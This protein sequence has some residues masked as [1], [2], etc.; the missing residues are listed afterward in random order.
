MLY[1]A[2]VIGFIGSLHCVGMCG[3][4][5]LMLPLN[6]KNSVIAFLQIMQYHL[7]RILSY[8]FLGLIFGLFGRGLF[9]AG[10]QQ[11]LSLWIG[12]LLIAGL[13]MSY[14]FRLK[15]P[16]FKPYTRLLM[17]LQASMGKQLKKRSPYT[18]FLMG[19]LNGFLPCGMVYMALFGAVAM[20]NPA[21][22][23][24]YMLAFGLG[25]I[26]LMSAVA[27]LGKKLP[28][29][30]RINFR[31]LT[32]LFILIIGVYFMIRG[33]GL[34]NYWSPALQQMQVKTQTD[35]VSPAMHHSVR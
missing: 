9:V 6:R 19:L 15:I 30:F 12:A 3:P 4:I 7:G 25:T 21:E 16:A 35:C 10:M 27:L 24:F 13:L 32:P 11:K 23:A 8:T 28:D 5:A 22:G 34:N 31:R 1:S 26:P 2:L 29:V 33:S 14:L 20:G 17:R 18:P